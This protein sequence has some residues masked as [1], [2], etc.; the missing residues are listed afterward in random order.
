MDRFSQAARGSQRPCG[1]LCT[2]IG[3]VSSLAHS[4]PPRAPHRARPGHR[5]RHSAGPEAAPAPVWPLQVRCQAQAAHAEAAQR[6]EAD[7]NAGNP[8]GQWHL[9]VHGLHQREGG[10]GGTMRPVAAEAQY[11]GA[12]PP[13]AEVA[14]ARRLGAL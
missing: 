2:E 10:L 12:S 9:D 1:C 11:G 3:R 5:G 4:L 8:Q 7:V 13:N 6:I 14:A